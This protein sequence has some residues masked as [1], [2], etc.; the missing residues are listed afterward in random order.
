MQLHHAAHIPV[1]ALFYCLFKFNEKKTP[2]FASLK[3][4]NLMQPYAIGLYMVKL[5]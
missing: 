4:C 5:Y 3:C 1:N 2:H